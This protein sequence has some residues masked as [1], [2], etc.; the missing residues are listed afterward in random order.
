MAF[1]PLSSSSKI[2]SSEL[3]DS[4]SVSKKKPAFL[5]IQVLKSLKL[6]NPTALTVRDSVDGVV[7]SSRAISSISR[8]ICFW[9]FFRRVSIM[10]LRFPFKASNFSLSKVI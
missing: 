9:A 2:L 8:N 10:T 3:T 1:T 4:S 6:L 7:L 5:A